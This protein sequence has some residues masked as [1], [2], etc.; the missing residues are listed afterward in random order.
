MNSLQSSLYTVAIALCVF[1]TGILSAKK[2]RTGRPL[3][4]FTAFLLIETLSFV[5]EL[6]MA[7]PAMPLKAL[8]LG[9][10]MSTGLLVAPCLWL[11]IKESMDGARPRLSSLGRSQLTLIIVGAALTL[12]LIGTAHLGVTYVNPTRIVSPLHS[13]VI[14]GTM[15][16]CIAIFAWQVPFYLWRCRRLLLPPLP[17]ENPAARDEKA[18]T[19]TWLHL[20]LVI[21]L[22]TWLLGLL[23]TVQ[24]ASHAPQE[25]TVL[26]AFIDVSVTVGAIYAMIRRAAAELRQPDAA[27]ESSRSVPAGR[28]TPPEPAMITVARPA[29]SAEPK[30]AKSSLPSPVR[31][32]IKR[33][34][35][36][37]LDR[38]EL[39]RDSL[40]G[41]TASE[42][43][44]TSCETPSRPRW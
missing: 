44:D 15:L 8:W 5:F 37:A 4:Y 42:N 10:R 18:K 28:E 12:P 19:L 31:E 25:F 16:L 14:H 33:K 21:L 13:R 38:E 22:T 3:A 1:S 34:L 43:S 30:Y 41:R 32:R 20:P 11:A 39:Y 7:H 9:L 36:S 40:S 6:L 35:E 26:F 23:R 27:Q 24:C 29:L 17:P 2:T